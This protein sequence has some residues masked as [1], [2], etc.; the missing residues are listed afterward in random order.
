MHGAATA[1]IPY[2]TLLEKF[3]VALM[4][5]SWAITA[6]ILML[7]FVYLEYNRVVVAAGIYFVSQVVFW[8]GCAIGG[9]ELVR[10]YRERFAWLDWTKRLKRRA[11]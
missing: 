8:A 6:T 4:A 11:E 1:S 2:M 5:G 7:P 3:A 9:R 10:R